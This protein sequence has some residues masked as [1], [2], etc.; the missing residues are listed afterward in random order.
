MAVTLADCQHSWND[1]R[2]MSLRKILLN[3]GAIISTTIFINRE[4][5]PRDQHPHM[6][7][8]QE[9]DAGGQEFRIPNNCTETAGNK[10][11]EWRT[12]HDTAC[13][14]SNWEPRSTTTKRPPGPLKVIIECL[15]LRSSLSVSPTTYVNRWSTACHAI[16]SS[17][18]SIISTPATGIK[19][20]HVSSSTMENSGIKMLTNDLTNC[21]VERI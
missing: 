4:T 13:L 1:Y 3:F 7:Q 12:A 2:R 14:L 21:S 6:C 5:H 11:K 15:N 9:A 10:T 16:L 19:P 18:L 8:D 17:L 20:F